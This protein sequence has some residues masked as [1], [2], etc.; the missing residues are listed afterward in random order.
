MLHWIGHYMDGKAD[1]KRTRQFAMRPA[2]DCMGCDLG[3]DDAL[4]AAPKR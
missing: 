3:C 1:N 2:E 4:P